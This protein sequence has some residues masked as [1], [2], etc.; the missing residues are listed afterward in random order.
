MNEVLALLDPPA[1]TVPPTAPPLSQPPAG[2]MPAPVKKGGLSAPLLIVGL[3][4]VVAIVG[5]GVYFLLPKHT[6]GGAP[7]AAAPSAS[8]AATPVGLRQAVETALPGLSCSWLELVDS[9]QGGAKIK[10][11]GVAGSPATVQGA[12]IDAARLSGSTLQGS[13][14]D[15]NEVA[16]AD[17]AVCSALDAFRSVRA[18]AAPDGPELKTE[19]RVYEIER[20]PNGKLASRAV[21]NMAVRSPSQDF[22]L[23][24]LEPSGKITMIVPN[25]AAFDATRVNNNLI[26]DLGGDAYKLQIDAF[27]FRGWSGLLLVTGKGPF[28]PAL[29]T[30][31]AGSRDVAWYDK[32]RQT[33][34]ANGWKSEMVWYKVVDN[35]VAAA[36]PAPAGVNPA[37]VGPRPVQHRPGAGSTAA[38]SEENDMNSAE[39]GGGGGGYTPPAGSAYQYQPAGRP[40]RGPVARPSNTWRQEHQQPFQ[41]PRPG[42]PSY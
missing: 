41:A 9:D 34:A 31:P 10:L 25:R 16:P 6:P 23:L 8:T 15:L 36:A 39:F 17:Q 38:K 12:V 13:D 19:K 7:T 42:I 21:I 3:L 28:D 32:V 30:L 1:A 5:A 29:L 14:V 40:A 18:P 27:D 11:V 33:A 2:A 24:G 26:T 35:G 20:Q 4:A 22:A 37:A